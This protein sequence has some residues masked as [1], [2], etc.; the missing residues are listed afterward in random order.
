MNPNLFPISVQ[1]IDSFLEINGDSFRLLHSEGSTEIPSGSARSVVLEIHNTPGKT[2]GIVFSML[3]SPTRQYAGSGSIE[4]G[5]PYGR[6]Y[7]PLRVE[8]SQ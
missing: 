3:Q 2:L 7:F 6:I 1:Q 5:S 8:H 4:F